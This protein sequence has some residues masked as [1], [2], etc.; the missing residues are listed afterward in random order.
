MDLPCQQRTGCGASVG[1][2]P[3]FCPGASLALHSIRCRTGCPLDCSIG[4]FLFFSKRSSYR[5]CSS[6]GR[7]VFPDARLLPPRLKAGD[8]VRSKTALLNHFGGFLFQQ[9]C[10][11]EQDSLSPDLTVSPQA[12]TPCR[13][14]R[15][16][17]RNKAKR[18]EKFQLRCAVK[19][20]SE[21]RGFTA[22]LVKMAER[23]G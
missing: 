17:N 12:D 3:L 1:V 2:W 10:S 23:W 9:D 6:A 11:E 19:P 16:W 7:S 13:Q 15:V 5:P 14:R 18:Y 8:A 22:R 20:R 4:R 21:R